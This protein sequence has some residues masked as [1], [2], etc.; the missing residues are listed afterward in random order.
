MSEYILNGI[1]RFGS[2]NINSFTKFMGYV[3]LNIFYA[4][5]FTTPCLLQPLSSGHFPGVNGVERSSTEV[6]ILYSSISHKCTVYERALESTFSPY[7]LFTFRSD[8]ITLP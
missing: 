3:S 2:R 1:V 7:K 8:Q 5:T 4:F 6:I